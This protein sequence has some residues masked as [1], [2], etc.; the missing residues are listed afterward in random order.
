MTNIVSYLITNNLVGALLIV[1]VMLLVIVF[2][3]WSI[4]SNK[5]DYIEGL[6]EHHKELHKTI[7]EQEEA[8]DGLI[9][10][11]A[12]E[13]STAFTSFLDR[14]SG[15]KPEEATVARARAQ[16]RSAVAKKKV[17]SKKVKAKK[18]SF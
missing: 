16:K 14:L 4:I 6:E 13:L 2:Y 9:E 8:L 12:K 7:A 10:A 15:K 11:K 3:F 18:D 1:A 17:A 5:H